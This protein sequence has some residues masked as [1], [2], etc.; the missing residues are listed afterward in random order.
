MC[1]HPEALPAPLAEAGTLP[2]ARLSRARPQ[3]SALPAPMPFAVPPP[4]PCFHSPHPPTPPT[5]PSLSDHT[6]ADP[7]R[8][9]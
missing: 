6:R 7:R 9:A 4:S 1:A 5:P 8:R 3:L 2:C